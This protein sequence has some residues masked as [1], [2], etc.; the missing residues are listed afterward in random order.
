MFSRRWI[1]CFFVKNDVTLSQLISI[2]SDTLCSFS[3]FERCCC[4]VYRAQMIFLLNSWRGN[5]KIYL[6]CIVC[7]CSSMDVVKTLNS[8]EGG[9]SFCLLAW[10]VFSLLWTAACFRLWSLGIWPKRPAALRVFRLSLYCKL[11]ECGRVRVLMPARVFEC[12]G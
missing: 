8:A 6:S 5:G 4:D 10:S 11:S 1:Y 12:A 7:H 2:S 9:Q 3:W